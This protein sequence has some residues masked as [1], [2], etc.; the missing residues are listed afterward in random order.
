MRIDETTLAG[1]RADHLSARA[2]LALILKHVW[3]LVRLGVGVGKSAAID[4]LLA[5]PDLY[6]R[7][8]L[9]V[10]VAPSWD[11]IRER[12]IVT[13]TTAATAGYR[14][15]EP[16]PRTR[17]GARDAP[18]RALER[19]GC[20]A[21]AKDTLCGSCPEASAADPCR[22]P[23]RL[24]D[25][26]G[27]HLF[28]ATEE[29]L[30]INRALIPMLKARTKAKRVLVVLDE[31]RFIDGAF[32]IEIDAR[33]LAMFD[34]ALTKAAADTPKLGSLIGRWRHA[35]AQVKS[36]TRAGL[37]RLRLEVPDTLLRH[38]LKIE[39]AGL[40]MHG[41][42]FRFLGYDLVQLVHSRGSERRR[43]TKGDLTFIARPYLKTHLLVASA[44]LD[45]EYVGQRLGEDRVSSPF[46]KVVVR[47]S[48][49]RIVNLRSRLGADSYFSKNSK[50]VLD[51]FALL[52]RR[53]VLADRTT[54]LVCKLSRK[55]RCAEYLRTRL[56]EWGLD[57]AFLIEGERPPSAPTPTVIPVIHYGVLGT[58]DYAGYES[59]FC[60]TGYYVADSTLNHALDE[61]E[62]DP[63]GQVHIVTDARRVRRAVLVDRLVPDRDR[64]WVA[65]LYLRRLEVDPVIQAVGRVRFLTQPRE[66]VTFQMADLSAEL[67]A[68]EEVKSVA[69]LRTAFRLPEPKAL[70]TAIACARIQAL[71]DEGLSVA[72]AGERIG[73]SRST[74]F[75]RARS[76]DSLRSPDRDIFLKRGFE[77]PPGATDDAGRAS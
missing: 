36:A 9:V 42:R 47:H 37:K 68:V 48:G 32:R 72:Q 6:R 76:A 38:A 19:R 51:T 63:D 31:A 46:E 26:E 54:L 55:P 50:Q 27:I 23:K 71:R 7:F 21:T 40:D 41:P 57:V 65:N 62:L 18:W 16:R 61:L 3:V 20:I 1:F 64:A 67:G 44:H 52:I 12:G 43:N 13:G 70:D 39:E 75:R 22:W 15:L 49:T 24:K 10:Y 29:L 30:R 73:I 58:N 33:E 4:A 8:D 56:A 28:F 14:V 59:A 5:L 11:V 2:L 53:N 34:G 74:A 35:L 17:C 66:I 69:A 45:G 77:T 25:V 60:L